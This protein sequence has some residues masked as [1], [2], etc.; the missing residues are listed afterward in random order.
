MIFCTT[1]QFSILSSPDAMRMQS[2]LAEKLE[3]HR[4]ARMR[5]LADKHA[6]ERATYLDRAEGGSKAEDLIN[7]GILLFSSPVT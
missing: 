6:K 4:Q 7:V 3:K 5:Q 1:V 2:D